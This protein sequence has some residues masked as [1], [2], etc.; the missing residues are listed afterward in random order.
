MTLNRWDRAI[1]EALDDE[2][3]LVAKLGVSDVSRRG[4]RDR[5]GKLKKRGLA[6]SRMAPHYREREARITEAGKEAL[7]V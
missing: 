5:L 3:Q 6:D 7:R 4:L 1:L 2:W